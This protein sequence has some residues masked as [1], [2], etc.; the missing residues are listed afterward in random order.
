VNRPPNPVLDAA[1]ACARRGWPVFPCQPGCKAPATP[2]GHLDATTDPGQI[3]AWFAARPGLNL[4][5]ATG[6]PGPD[7]LDVDRR[8]SG[9]GFAALSALARA[10]L[11]AGSAAWVRTP[12]GGVHG[13][14]TGSRQHSAR[15]P[16][17]Y[18][19][20]KSAGGYVLVPPSQVGGR[21]YRL[22]AATGG[23]AGLDWQQVT[24]LLEPARN[25]LP[26][27][28]RSGRADVTRLAGWVARLEEGNR[29][30]GL[31]WAACRALDASPAAD[32]SSLAAA[33]RQA[34]L[35][36]REVAA[37]LGSAR[38]ITRQAARQPEAAI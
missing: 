16:G 38:R 7:V 4:A 17:C 18:L 35:G 36:E 19:D 21:P 2:H 24:A 12:G 22:I 28:P 1:L 6:A 37:T 25:C 15:L 34:G 30:A 23:T 11:T 27:R 32:L 29:N 3:A 14:Y 26:A 5:I 8:P 31:F 33:A 20:F 10:G 13:Y 9:S